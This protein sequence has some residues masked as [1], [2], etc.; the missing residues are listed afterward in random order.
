MK[1]EEA[2]EE[3]LNRVIFT[4]DP[5]SIRGESSRQ[6]TLSGKTSS[7]KLHVAEAHEFPEC[8][9]LPVADSARCYRSGK[10]WPLRVIWR[11][12]GPMVYMVD[13]K[14]E[15]YYQ[16]KNHSRP[17]KNVYSN[18]RGPL[19]FYLVCKTFN[20]SCT[21]PPRVSETSEPPPSPPPRHWG[22][23]RRPPSGLQDYVSSL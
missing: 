10:N 14:K 1:E 11:R 16:H 18:Q 8:K 9:G 12:Q 7:N 20:I 15:Q 19:T 21:F 4:P 22:R 23:N 3:N 2:S 6:R 5:S 17:R 13:V